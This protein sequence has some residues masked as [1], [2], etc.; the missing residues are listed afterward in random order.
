[1]NINEIHKDQNKDDENSDGSGAEIQM[2]DIVKKFSKK[3]K[4]NVESDL[5]KDLETLDINRYLD[6][7]MAVEEKTISD[8]SDDSGEEENGSIE[9]NDDEKQDLT[10]YPDFGMIISKNKEKE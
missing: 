3:P 6:Q 8:K 7:P 10:K 5:L 4:N 2:L 9:E 1:M